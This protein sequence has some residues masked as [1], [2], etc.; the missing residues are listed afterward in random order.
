MDEKKSH[1]IKN[2]FLP[3][4]TQSTDETSLQ[5]HQSL[6]KITSHILMLGSEV[7]SSQ[8]KYRHHEKALTYNTSL[9]KP[10]DSTKLLS[11]MVVLFS[12][13]S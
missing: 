6:Q 1:A 9:M 3:D 11:N 10:I 5:I 13:R 8:N 12:C 7:R 2:H 4:L